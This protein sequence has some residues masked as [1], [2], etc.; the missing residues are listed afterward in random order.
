VRGPLTCPVAGLRACALVLGALC[1]AS[2]AGTAAEPPPGL[3]PTEREVFRRIKARIIREAT[4]ALADDRFEGRGTLQPGG[5]EAAVWIADRMKTLGLAPGG[6]GD[7]YLQPVPLVATEF[8]EPTRV[9]VDGTPL[10]YGTDWSALGTFTDMHVSPPLVF[11]GHGMVSKKFGRDDLKDVDLRGK[12]AVCVEGPPADVTAEKWAEISAD[13]NLL[14]TLLARGVGGLISVSNGRELLPRAFVVDQTARRVISVPSTTAPR[15]I[16]LMFFGAAA[17]EGLL[18]KAGKTARQA[19]DE[20]DGAGFT[21]WPLAA[22]VDIELK[23][24]RKEGTSP[25][26]IGVIKGR[27]PVLAAE[28]VVFSAHYD[29]FGVLRQAIYN[30]AADN[31]IG[32]G[33]MLAVA[34]AFAQA[35]V[36]PRRS[37]VFVAF[38]AEE[39]G[40]IGSKHYAAHPTWDLAKTAAVLNLDGIGTEIMGPMKGMVAYGA[41]LSSLGPMFFQVARAYGITPMDDPIPT[42]GVFRRS[43]HYSLVERGVPGLM[44]VGS[45]VDNPKQF[46]ERFDEFERTKYHRPSDD[47]Y[48]DW[49]WKGARKVADMMALIGHRVAQADA[50]PSFNAGSEY[51]GRARGEAPRA[52]GR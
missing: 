44:L 8:V 13:A 49:Y 16:P 24:S 30:G 35:S 38:T 26:V 33:E 17:G 22:K 20:A 14:G 51:A 42:Q 6:E 36:K 1:L 28:A 11:V 15:G 37:L 34:E 47:V 2:A 41:P 52:A 4:K 31:A 23:S 48:R 3:S 10:T 40:L 21:P 5:D 19:F 18:A 9:S 12:I 50:M 29:G 27:D 46:S 25:N 43:D 39:Y 45:P 32:V 7:T